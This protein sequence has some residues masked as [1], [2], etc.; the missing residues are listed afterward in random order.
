MKKQSRMMQGEQNRKTFV[1]MWQGIA[2]KRYYIVF[3]LII[4]VLLGMSGGLLAL[5]LR[6]LIDHAVEGERSGFVAAG[7]GLVLLV[8]L[9]ITFRAVDRYLEEKT[10]S[11]YE[12]IW[13]K[14]LFSELMGRSY[15]E[16]TQIHSG[17]WMNRL[18]SDT[19]IVADGLAQIVPGVCGMLTRILIAVVLLIGIMPEL[20]YVLIPGGL[21]LVFLTWIFRR[22]LKRLH[23]KVQEADG[24]LR[25]FLSER[26]SGLVILHTFVKE[27][28]TADEA[29]RYMN[30]HQGSRMKKNRFSNICNIGFGA[31]MNGAY[32]LGA[33]YCGYGILKGQVSY[34]TFIAVLQLV[35]QIQTPFA[36]LSGYFP[37]YFACLASAERLMQAETFEPD[38]T[39]SEILPSDFREQ[40]M[41][42]EIVNG[43]FAYR[44]D[45][46][47][48]GVQAQTDTDYC[49]RKVLEHF[50]MHIAKG[51][52][53]ALTGPSGC[54]KSTV[55]KIL[56]S[57]Y[58]LDSG[59]CNVIFGGERHKMH[60]GFRSLFAYVPQGNHLMSGTIK[61]AVAFGEHV[62]TEKLTQALKAA[63]AEFVYQLP[64]QMETPLGEQGHGLSE[65]Q[66]Q[67]LAVARAVYSGHPVLILD[68]ATSALD[69]Q[70]EKRLLSNLRAMT[71]RTV[72]I[73]THRP[74]ALQVCDRTIAMMTD[75]EE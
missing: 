62:D 65:G 55:L 33:I 22:V 58:A 44:R 57:L 72:L 45:T 34:G 21:L 67:R 47:L 56:M 12:N 60:A 29:D 20:A 53:L 6:N 49:E 48:L 61:E 64:E 39:G 23:K 37:K 13:K 24:R 68:E 52:F 35:A 8:I 14:R 38:R 5:L 18:T 74:A 46:D 7:T 66:I 69:E 17:E 3:L 16:V 9:Q 70:T 75:R 51:E 15:R 50:N 31:A 27:Q 41:A 59:D 40:F 54:G 19:V 11:T 25:I 26:L 28:K 71:D 32:I 42:L 36:N 4:S 1:W 73:V 43:S 10:R 63:C 2:G 30:A